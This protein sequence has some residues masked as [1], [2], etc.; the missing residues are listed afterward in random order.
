MCTSLCPAVVV[1][2][3]HAEYQAL[4]PGVDL[5]T[6]VEMVGL[7][8]KQA[9]RHLSEQLRDAAEK[10]R[11]APVI[12]TLRVDPAGALAAQ[13]A[14]P[15]RLTLARTA[16]RDDGDPA[17][18]LPAGSAETAD[19]Y[20]A[21]VGSLLLGAY[22]AAAV[23]LH[24]RARRYRP[25]DV[26]HWLENIAVGLVW[27]DRCGGSGTDIAL[28]EWWGGGHATELAYA[29]V[30]GLFVVLWFTALAV[31]AH[32]WLAFAGLLAFGFALEDA[33]EA[34]RPRRVSRTYWLF[35]AVV[36]TVVIPLLTVGYFKLTHAVGPRISAWQE[37]LLQPLGPVGRFVTDFPRW[38]EAP[39]PGWLVAVGVAVGAGW[40]AAAFGASVVYALTQRDPRPVGPRDVVRINTQVAIGLALVTGA[41]FSALL[42]PKL[43]LALA[44]KIGLGSGIACGL[45]A[46]GEWI[47]YGV[48]VVVDAIRGR[49]PLRFGAFLDWARDAG[50]LRVSGTAYQFRH[51]QLQDW[52]THGPRARGQMPGTL[53][54][55]PGD[56]RYGESP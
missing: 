28:D 16:F 51:R 3:R 31:V 8:G 10:R 21:A 9:A 19:E 7:T 56:S 12:D 36:T 43:G 49:S 33:V 54:T 6:H 18:L 22:V 24:G 44:L 1:T 32:S 25:A 40:L 45:A 27:Q 53:S 26:E 52:L 4:G 29:A 47:R 46:S 39:F 2:C 30:V 20:A 17:A 35:I 13:L 50:L 38:L 48:T 5:A 14:T 15:W 41:G 37:R 11:W 23:S 55:P 42:T 34:D